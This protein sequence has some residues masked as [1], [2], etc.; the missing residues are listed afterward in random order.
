MTENERKRKQKK[1]VKK[2]ATIRISIYDEKIT[3][4]VFFF[5]SGLP[6]TTKQGK[7]YTIGH[8]GLPRNPA[9]S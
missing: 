8:F 6:A 2:V 9:R 5:D 3:Y 1:E 7:L 4:S